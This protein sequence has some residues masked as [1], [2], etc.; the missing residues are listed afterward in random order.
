MLMNENDLKTVSKLNMKHPYVWIATWFGAGFM[1]P[2]PGTWGSAAAIPFLLILYKF[3]GLDGVWVG[4]ITITAFGFWASTLFDKATGGHDNKMI[5]VDEVVGQWLALL[6]MLYLSGMNV[7]LTLLGFIFFRF[8]DIL[9]P[10]PIS[11]LDKRCGG[12]MGVMVDDILAGIAAAALLTGYI[13]Y[14]GFI[15]F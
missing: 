1:C 7:T 3:Q 13:Q 6:P 15:P 9:K 14:V 2:G 10:W 5:V 12:A 4:L 8:F 11:W